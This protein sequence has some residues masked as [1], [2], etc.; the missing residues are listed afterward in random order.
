M[1]PR[2]SHPW[3]Q[4]RNPNSLANLAPH[5]DN[6]TGTGPG[7]VPVQKL[8]AAFKRSG[9]S[10]S[11]LARRMGWERRRPDVHRVNQYLGMEDSSSGQK[12]KRV[13]YHVA[14]RL[15]R[16]MNIDPFECGV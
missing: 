11:E 10:K 5:P 8:Q 13:T 14:L 12:R 6:L 9:L 15:C 2:N 1:K 3:K 4:G 7:E 16:A